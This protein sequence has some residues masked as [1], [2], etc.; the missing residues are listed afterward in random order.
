LK[1]HTNFF[2]ERLQVL[3]VAP[4]NCYIRKFENQHGAGYITADIESPLAKVKMDLLKIPFADNSFDVVLC[5]HV[6]E[7]VDDDLKA[8]SE[9][10]R[11][12]K[13][14]GWS[15][16]QIPFFKPIP[17]KTFSDNTITNSREREKVFGQSDHVRRYGSDYPERIASCGFKVDQESF[18][19]GITPDECFRLGLVP[20]IIYVARKPK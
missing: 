10:F 1:D 11:V 13:P 9:I 19:F 7:H 17:E 8:L 5:N 6:L 4:E 3:H 14:G 12:L 18:S 16:L 20:E 15:I 2:K